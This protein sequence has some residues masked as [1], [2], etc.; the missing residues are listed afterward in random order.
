MPKSKKLAGVN[1]PKQETQMAEQ[2]Y[3]AIM[4]API[5]DC[6]CEPCQILRKLYKDM[7]T[8]RSDGRFVP[9]EPLPNIMEG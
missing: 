1:L 7:V 9:M 2:F 6:Q 4:L 5:S 3:R 8:S